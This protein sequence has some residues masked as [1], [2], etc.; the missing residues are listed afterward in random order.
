M[1]TEELVVSRIRDGTVIDHI[2]AGQALNVL[3]ILGVRGTEGYTVALIMNVASKKLGK[4]DMVK[5]EGRELK[6]S[7]VDRIAL[8]AP[9][10]TINTIREYKVMKKATVRLPDEVRGLL[11]CTNPSC[12]SVKPREPVVPTFSVISRSPLLLSCKYCGTHISQEEVISQ[13]AAAGG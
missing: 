4:K 8:I 9:D 1:N 5:I 11:S 13:Y 3:R 10:A 6:P 12:I 2:T 7:E